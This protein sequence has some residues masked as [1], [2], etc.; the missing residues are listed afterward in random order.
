MNGPVVNLETR[1]PVRRK[2]EF[3]ARPGN[4]GVS[5]RGLEVRRQEIFDTALGLTIGDHGLCHLE[6]L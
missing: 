1:L 2:I 5:V 4:T 3:F 6:L